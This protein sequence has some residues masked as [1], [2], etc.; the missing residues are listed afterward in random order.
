MF[1][2][3]AVGLLKAIF[4]LLPLMIVGWFVLPIVLLFIPKERES[5]PKFFRCWDNFSGPAEDGLAGDL[6]FRI[7]VGMGTGTITNY[8]ETCGYWYRW[9]RRYVWLAFRN[10]VDYTKGKIL[11][12]EFTDAKALFMSKEGS[13]N[14]VKFDTGDEF[15]ELYYYSGDSG[16]LGLKHR[17]RIGYKCDVPQNLEYQSSHPHLKDRKFLRFEFSYSPYH[18][19]R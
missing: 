11:G 9:W 18:P 7:I 17:V 1:R 19:N 10:P 6:G 4:V 5:L 16:Y 8:A 13:I 14:T 15:S 2:I 12:G 3:I